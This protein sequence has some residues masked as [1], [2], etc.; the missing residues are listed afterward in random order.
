MAIHLTFLGNRGNKISGSQGI[1]GND[2]CIPFLGSMIHNKYISGI[3]SAKVTRYMLLPRY[4]LTIEKLLKPKVQKRKR[5]KT[6]SGQNFIS[7]L[8]AVFFFKLVQCQS[9]LNCEIQLF[10][11]EGVHFTHTKTHS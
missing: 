8:T 2:I 4:V 5:E 7:L 11:V 10:G 6:F 9:Q 3:G 1:S